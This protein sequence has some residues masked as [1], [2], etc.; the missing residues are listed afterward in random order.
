[1]TKKIKILFVTDSLDCGGK[2]RQLVELVRNRNKEKSEYHVISMKSGCF[3]DNEIRESANSFQVIERK[4]RWDF[5]VLFRFATAIKSLKPD[6]IHGFNPMTS[7]ILLVTCKLF[8][9]KIPVIN[10]GLRSAPLKFSL[11]AKFFRF[12]LKFYKI[13]VANSYAGLQAYGEAGKEGRFVLYNGFNLNRIPELTKSEARVKLEF[14]NDKFIIPMVAQVSNRKD[15][16]TLINAIQ[17]LKKQNKADS[18]LC[19]IVG[20]GNT[21]TELENL[22]KE[23]QLEDT[24]QFLGNRRDV[25][26]IFKASDLSVLCTAD[27]WGEGISNSILESLACGVPVIA[28]DNGGTKEVIENG[29]NGFIIEIG[30]A[31]GLA[32]KIVFLKSNRNILEQFSNETQKTV[33][34]KFGIEKMVENYEEFYSKLFN[35]D[36]LKEF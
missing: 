6:F 25:E 7:L 30:D 4:W 1:M 12:F 32:E 3:F 9:I 24:I 21:R 10:G 16:K 19:L 5:C 15:Q 8:S 26:L 36:Y 23:L 11:H 27:W 14:L 13:V 20:D 2:E 18:I 35:K 31:E 28:T 17:I 22:T 33:I 34:E 29:K